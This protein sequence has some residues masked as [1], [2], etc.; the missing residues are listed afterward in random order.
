MGCGATSGACPASGRGCGNGGEFGAT[1]FSVGSSLAIGEPTGTGAVAGSSCDAAR[2]AC[3]ARA[4][5]RRKAPAEAADRARSKS[6]PSHAHPVEMGRL[7]APGNARRR[8]ICVTLLAQPAI[9]AGRHGRSPAFRRRCSMVEFVE[10]AVARAA[11]PVL[12]R[13]HKNVKLRGDIRWI[14]CAGRICP[15]RRS[16]VKEAIG[17]HRCRPDLPLRLPPH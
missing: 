13:V 17:E 4:T 15:P 3:T 2:Q 1:G 5:K 6:I 16:L 14:R 10:A 12:F 9:A 8:S 11:C 7:R